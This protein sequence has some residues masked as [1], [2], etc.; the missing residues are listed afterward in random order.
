MSDLRESVLIHREQ[1]RS[2][3]AGA[4]LGWL[5]N[6][7]DQGAARFAEL[8]L[9]GARDE[10]WR[11]T[12]LR[13]I[14][15]D[16]PMPALGS[17]AQAPALD[18]I[19]GFDSY[20]L[21]FI[22]G[23]FDAANSNVSESELPQGVT[24]S[25]LRHLLESDPGRLQSLLGSQ[26]E[27]ESDRLEDGL[28]A[29]NTAFLNDGAVVLVDPGVELSKSVELVF[30]TSANRAEAA[31]LRT[32]ICVGQGSSANV[33]ERHVGA[34]GAKP[35]TH[36]V[37]EVTVEDN[38][39]LR[40]IRIQDE[41]QDANHLGGTWVG[42][43]RDGRYQHT[44]A[45][46]GG[47]LIRHDLQVRLN[48]SGAHCQLNGL[49]LGSG[50]R[51]IDNHTTIE[52]VAPHCTSDEHYRSVLDDKSRSVFHGRIRVHEN[53]QKTD[54]NQLN[55]S[56]LL[57]ADAEADCKPQL[58]I[59]ADDVKCSHGATVGQLDED[60]RFYLQSRGIDAETAGALLTLAFAQHV[61]SDIGIEP[62]RQYL[63]QAVIHRL[64]PNALI[65]QSLINPAGLRADEGETK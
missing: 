54:A 29:L 63:A 35:L 17:G 50:R 30:A 62:V 12:N 11:Y 64:V 40:H 55:K 56:L 31:L 14:S 42:V 41:A 6:L 8:G 51:H 24:I 2:Q 58:E 22:D 10:N 3:F 36:A 37:S 27:P 26:I 61:L 15:R 13:R 1:L 59:Y 7:R 21:S 18:V 34:G 49:V 57:S 23:A 28:R 9:P 48:Q 19:A 47:A 60:S 38:A 46:L 25:S 43:S 20:R 32:V 65:D 39:S 53:A 4:G 33:V 45:T 44:I 52:H 5:D 16:F